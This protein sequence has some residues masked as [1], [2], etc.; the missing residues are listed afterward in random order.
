MHWV[1]HQISKREQFTELPLIYCKKRFLSLY[2]MS[3]TYTVS[4]GRVRELADT[5]VLCNIASIRLVL[6]SMWSSVCDYSFWECYY[7]G[8][9]A[10]LSL[11]YFKSCEVSVPL[12]L[13]AS[14]CLIC[15][16]SI[17]TDDLRGNAHFSHFSSP[18][19]SLHSEMS[20]PNACY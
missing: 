15:L 7:F 18:L 3:Y 19:H 2:D 9:C 17:T 14:L 1:S 20:N 11:F 10:L 5:F 13:S 4:T 8:L 6:P 12:T 16:S